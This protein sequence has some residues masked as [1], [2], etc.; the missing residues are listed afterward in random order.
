V[1]NKLGQPDNTTVDN[2]QPQHQ[3]KQNVTW[4]VAFKCC[5]K[6]YHSHQTHTYTQDANNTVRNVINSLTKSL[7]YDLTIEQYVLSSI[8][9]S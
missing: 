3:T 7:K 1:E 8:T 4:K 5:R 9:Y 6:T 2:I